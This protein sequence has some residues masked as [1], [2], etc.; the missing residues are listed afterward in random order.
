[1]S[2]L[3]GAISPSSLDWET[4]RALAY[5]EGH[6]ESYYES[7]FLHYMLHEG[8]PNGGDI[9]CAFFYSKA[10]ACEYYLGECKSC[11]RSADLI[12]FWSV[13][14]QRRP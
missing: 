5:K 2:A 7:C 14:L 6:I 13:Q 3:R 8:L 10:R 1:M 4:Y 11:P 9:L 12:S